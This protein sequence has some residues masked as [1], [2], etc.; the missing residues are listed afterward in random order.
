MLKLG[1]TLTN[2]KREI[3]IKIL[4]CTDTA[5]LCWWNFLNAYG[6][7][8]RLAFK[9]LFET[10]FQQKNKFSNYTTLYDQL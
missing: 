1:Q 7:R 8:A 6:E 2:H 10:Y 5:K 4:S 3:D 9:K